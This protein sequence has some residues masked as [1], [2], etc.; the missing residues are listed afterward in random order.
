MNASIGNAPD[1]SF[2]AVDLLVDRRKVQARARRLAK[3]AEILANAGRVD[4]A[5]VC[6]SELVGLRPDDAVA[7]LRLGLLYRE[8]RRIDAALLEFRRASHLSPHLCDPR[9]ALIETLLDAEMFEETIREGRA[10][11]RLAPRNLFARDVLSIAYLQMGMIDKALHMVTEMVRFDP[12]NPGN[13]FKRA[14]LLQQQGN[15]SDAMTE[16]M[17]TRDLSDPEC[18]LYSDALTALDAMDEYQ[19]HTI[20]LLA[21]E[22]LHFNHQLRTDP[23]TA[24]RQRGF[25]LSSDGLVRAQS[26]AL[27]GEIEPTAG[28]SVRSSWGGVRFYN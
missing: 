1:S 21:C 14:L 2:S 22:D 5:I 23:T 15:V 25:I 3:R 12:M 28:R 19:L 20:M 6:Q 10:L 7:A 27:E 24:T 11:L 16:Y 13:H 8:A 26:F 4:E 18:E 9:E 17:R